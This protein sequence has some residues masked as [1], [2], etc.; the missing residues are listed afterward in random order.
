M[1]STF[2]WLSEIILFPECVCLS[3]LSFLFFCVVLLF[4]C[5]TSI[6]MPFAV[7]CLSAWGQF[8]LT[9]TSMDKSFLM[10]PF[11]S[12]KHLKDQRST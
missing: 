5:C 4:H 8:Y 6:M 7:Y 9:K 10:P 3:L 1:L 12:E 2:S 11:P